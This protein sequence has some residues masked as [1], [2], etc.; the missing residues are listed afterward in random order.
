MRKKIILCMWIQ[1]ILLI[2]GVAM[3]ICNPILINHVAVLCLVVLHAVFTV[4]TQASFI[5][6]FG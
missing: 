1:V 4:L 3:I 2:A 5:E 6:K